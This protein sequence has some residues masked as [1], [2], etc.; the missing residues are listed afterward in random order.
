MP[1]LCCAAVPSRRRCALT[2]APTEQVET[3]LATQDPAGTT[4]DSAKAAA[5]ISRGNEKAA[6]KANFGVADPSINIASSRDMDRWHYN[7]D[8]PPQP[9]S[10]D[11]FNFNSNMN[12][13]MSNVDSQ[14]TW[15]IINLGLDEPLPPQDTIDELHQIYFE[16]IH[17]SFPMI[18]KYRY[19]AAMNL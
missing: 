16:K 14:F 10:I 3:L 19:L 11:E 17:P 13:N 18:H 1:Y 6:A 9:G 5:S 15:E 8:S 12:M 7:A 2:R 4:P